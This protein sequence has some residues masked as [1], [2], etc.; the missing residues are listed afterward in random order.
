MRG[1]KSSEQTIYHDLE[2]ARTLLGDQEQAIEHVSECRYRCLNITCARADTRE[3]DPELVQTR[4]ACGHMR[5]QWEPQ[6]MV[7][8]LTS[9]EYASKDGGASVDL[10]AYLLEINATGFGVDLFR[11]A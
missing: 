2:V 8:E 6:G 5:C 4:D 9:W 7:P 10:D 1:M 11:D 3:T